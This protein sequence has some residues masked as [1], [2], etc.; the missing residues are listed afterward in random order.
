QTIK[1]QESFMDLIEVYEKEERHWEKY[2]RYTLFAFFAL[3]IITFFAYLDIAISWKYLLDITNQINISLSI[4]FHYFSLSVSITLF[5]VLY[6]F[7]SQYIKA[8]NL[9]IE[10]QNKVALIYGYQALQA[11]TNANEKYQYFLPNFSNVIFAK[12]IPSKNE[13]NLPIDELVKLV[14][15]IKN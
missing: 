7:I 6:F 5:T 11:E 4:P 9:R 12:A 3:F 10:N 13:K 2:I 15:A 1:L 8:K 14:K